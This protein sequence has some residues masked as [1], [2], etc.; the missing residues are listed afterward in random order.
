[1]KILF[2]T[3]IPSP[4]F[5]EY[6][7]ELGKYAEITV[8]FEKESFAHR[9]KSWKNFN[10]DNFTYHYLKGINISKTLI[11]D[12]NATQYIKD[13]PDALVVI[14][15]PLTPVGMQC[16]EYCRRHKRTYILQSEGG[17]PK[18]GKGLK[19]KIKYHFL[20]GASMYLSGMKAENDY[21]TAYGANSKSIRTYPFASLH[22][23][24]LIPELIDEEEKNAIKSE[25]GMTQKKI[26]LF[27]GRIIPVKGIDILIRS[28][29][30]LSNDTG[31]YLVGG[32][33]VEP[34]VS[35][36]KELGVNNL[37]YISHAPLNILRKY[38]LAADVFVL[39]TRGDTWGLVINEAMTY[40]LPVITTRNCV[41]GVQLI[42][43]GENGFL[44]DNEDYNNLRRKID[45][46]LDDEKLR[47]EMSS[48]NLMKMKSY[49]YEN[50]AYVIYNYLKDIR[51]SESDS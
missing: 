34:Y 21:F 5:V 29:Q 4:Y 24:D 37:N 7:N 42:Q 17:I 23:K 33:A 14:A 50:M 25:L 1:M 47:H 46:I 22:E 40:G 9:D 20:H 39:P 6:I 31:V 19:E 18:D 36:A 11:I 30:G 12:F 43:D 2:Y 16:I 26:V 13:N 10:S 28:C 44:I 8:V 48:N 45:I 27:V 38:Y 49:T 3:N 15:S 51:L 41:A 35:L 32:E